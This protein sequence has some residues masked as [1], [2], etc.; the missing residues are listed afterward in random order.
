MNTKEQ[1]LQALITASGSFRS[2]EALAQSLGISRA[3]V[4]KAV[5]ALQNE[6]YAIDAVTRRGYRL[7]E[8]NDM[9]S[10]AA[11]QALVDG[12]IEVIYYA[13]VDSTNTEAKRLL[14]NGKDGRLL[15][16]AEEQTAGRGRQGKSFYS[17]PLT[18][19]YMTYVSHPMATLASAVK[20]TTLAAVAVCRAV[21]ALTDKQPQIKWVN[22]VYL[23]EKKICGI[24]TEAVTDM[25]TQAV[26]S[27]IVGIGMNIKTVHFPE[28]AGN[29]ASL[30]APVRRAA[31]IA[32]ITR[33]LA[34]AESEPFDEVLA[35]YRSHSLLL[36]R[37]IAFIKNGAVTPATVKAIDNSGGLVVTLENGTEQTLTSG[38]IS[39][40]KQ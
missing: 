28:E 12:D 17:P 40:R 20:T 25:E 39:I 26:S 36:G 13:S 30:N 37:Q 3:A 7:N 15:L 2:G 4:W 32:Q 11:V 21:E 24:L 14:A 18:G 9:L 34:K 23:G 10:A 6:G 8:D 31:L 27:V 29:A 1:V 19:I 38:E 22:D 5:R 33:E 16:I 35:Y